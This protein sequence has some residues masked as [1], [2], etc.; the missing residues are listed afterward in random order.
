M[1]ADP[2]SESSIESIFCD[3]DGNYSEGDLGLWYTILES[4]SSKWR[5]SRSAICCAELFIEGDLCIMGSY[6]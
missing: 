5:S 6:S 2:G 1:R 3:I 4:T